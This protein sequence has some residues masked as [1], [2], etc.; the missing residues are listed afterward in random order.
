M[1]NIDFNLSE[2]PDPYEFSVINLNK[3]FGSIKN[4]YLTLKAKGYYI[5]EFD[6]R[7]VTSIYLLKIAKDETC[8]PKVSEIK[9]GEVKVNNIKRYCRVFVHGEINHVIK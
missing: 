6:K 3:K 8:C 2:V 1:S 9:Q 4:L 5:P 7:L